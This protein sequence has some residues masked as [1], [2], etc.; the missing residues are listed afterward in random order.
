MALAGEAGGQLTRAEVRA[1]LRD[2]TVQAAAGPVLSS[3]HTAVDEVQLVLAARHGHLQPLRTAQAD[4]GGRHVPADTAGRHVGPELA[5]QGGDGH[6]LPP[7]E[8][9]QLLP[10][11]QRRAGGD[12]ARVQSCVVGREVADLEDIHIAS[13]LMQHLNPLVTGDHLSPGCQKDVIA[14][15][16][17]NFFPQETFFSPVGDHTREKSSLPGHSRN[18]L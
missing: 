4:T 9:L 6:H 10:G 8:H 3:G 7:G 12:L 2:S 16:L 15:A 5:L 11:D 14:S 17:G 1:F 13:L 18:S